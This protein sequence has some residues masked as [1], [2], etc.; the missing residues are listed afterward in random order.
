MA[1]SPMDRN[2][3][4]D[5]L[6]QANV[7]FISFSE[8]GEIQEIS[9]NITNLLSKPSGDFLGKNIQRFIP[10]SQLDEIRSYALM[11]R[12]T[13]CSKSFNVF[14]NVKDKGIVGF[15]A[16]LSFSPDEGYFCVLIPIE[17]QIA[18]H[19]EGSF[20]QMEV[21]RTT[22]ESMDDFVFVLDRNG[23]FTEFYSHTNKLFLSGI[24]SAFKVGSPI[25]DVGFPEHVEELFFKAI[26]TTRKTRVSTQVS[27]SINAFG[28]ELFYQ[29]KISPRFTLNEDFDGVTI[30][31]R[32]TTTA[33][34]GEEKLK[35]SLEYYLTVLD[36]FPNPIL[37]VNTMKRS[38][39]FNKTWVEFTGIGASIQKDSGW[40][41]SLFSSDV[42]HVTMEFDEKFKDKKPFTLEFRL[43]HN[44][45]N[46]RW[47][48]C[49]WQPLYDFK[50]RFSGYMGSCFDIDD[51][52]NTQKLLQESESRYRAM[53]QEQSDIVVRWKPNLTISFVNKS[54]CQFFNKNYNQL[55]GANWVGLFAQKH[56]KTIE[57][58]LLAFM[59]ANKSMFFETEILN[60]NNELFV[61]QWLNSPITDK[62]GKIIEYQSVGRDIT[63]KIDKERENQNL[64]LRLNEKVKELS[65]LNKVSR[66]INDGFME[67]HLF[68]SLAN[69]II[70]SFLN[71]S[72]TFAL[73]EYGTQTFKS[74]NFK[75]LENFSIVSHQFGGQQ[76]GIINVFRD[77][78]IHKVNDAEFIEESEIGLLKTVC[79]MLNSYL[80]KLEADKKLVQSEMRFSELFENVM[81]IVFSINSSGE[82]LKI[83]SAATKILGFTD[84]DGKNLWEFAA[85]SEKQLII[86]KLR[87]V[88]SQNQKSFTFETR[89]LSSEGNMIFL[90]IGGIIKYKSSSKPSEIFGIARDITEQ[91]RLEQ[92]IMK[93][94]ITTEEK[95]RKRFAEDLHDGIGPLLSGL[96]MYLQQDTLEK[97]LNEKQQKVLKYCR[98]LVDDAIGQTRSIANNLTPSVLNDFGLE[99]ALISHASKINAIGKFTVDLQIKTSLA[100]VEN[101]IAIAIFRIVSELINNALKHA[102]CSLVEVTINIKKNIL[103]LIYMDNGKGFK[104]QNVESIGGVVK[105]GLNSIKNRVH[106]LNGSITI[107]SKRGEGVF[108][109]IFLPLR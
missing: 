54:F 36:N 83:N 33:V 35:K 23:L 41:Q 55:I 27:Y 71:P 13:F 85:P 97:D 73:I 28:G 18:E 79:E 17:S 91:R 100:S 64:L 86:N 42:Q 21:M 102:G 47:I 74:N 66:Y 31:L 8:Q 70:G 14:L 44:S 20:R 69:D 92:S 34:K 4:S 60:T 76:K 96:K 104:Q 15:L 94:V 7:I 37:R 38:D 103:S 56:Q 75:T 50:G 5:K 89:V 2:K 107:D 43:I 39:Y 25:S 10:A 93:T 26:E 105:M 53:V 67:T 22:L 16:S 88:V 12:E 84:F 99:K 109:K 72:A 3:L 82:I 52:R 1:K 32:D 78:T 68:R 59:N 98:E 57:N 62:K 19:D 24:S 9:K 77:N 6:L 40:H 46:Y 90:Q 45:G 80:L 87:K 81:D 101:D 95:E 106:S 11:V 63:E 29:A 58:Q 65:L 30:V 61:F 49:F 48:K 108:V 51:I